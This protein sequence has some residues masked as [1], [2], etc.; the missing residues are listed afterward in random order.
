MLLIM[1][2]NMEQLLQMTVKKLRR[3]VEEQVWRGFWLH[4]SLTCKK[5][6][7]DEVVECQK[8]E[9]GSVQKQLKD[10]EITLKVC[11]FGLFCVVRFCS[12]KVGGPTSG[13]K[14]KWKKSVR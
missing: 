8:A 1:L 9:I 6:K 3:Q 12:K 2:K 4:K 13:R 10:M 14:T 11:C 7:K 5:K